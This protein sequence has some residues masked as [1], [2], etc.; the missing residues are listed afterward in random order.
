MASIS[1]LGSN[2][3]QL[4]N[5]TSL[6]DQMNLMQRQ[7]STGKKYSSY[8]ELGTNNIAVQRARDLIGN[9][10]SLNRN[11]DTAGRR[12]EL[13]TSALDTIVEQTRKVADSIA[14]E[15]QRG[16]ADLDTI[17]QIAQTT[18]QLVSDL[19]NEQDG[20]RYLFNGSDTRTQPFTD[21]GSLDTF[22]TTQIDD[23][24]NENITSEELIDQYREKTNLSDSLAGFSASISSGTA[25]DISVRIENGASIN[26]GVKANEQPLRDILV[27]LKMIQNFTGALDEVDLNADAAP[28]TVTAPGV[29]QQEQQD[30]FYAVFND[31]ANM[32]NSAAN[33]VID[34]I[35]NLSQVQV[36]I[37]ESQE[38]HNRLI[39]VQQSIISDIEDADIN[40]IALRF[41]SVTTQL[42][43]SFSLTSTL[44]Q[45]SLLNFL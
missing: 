34:R 10:E 20:D 43:A 23:W 9:L 12:I 35:S 25:K 28:G 44:R 42:N 2:L 37:N 22:L 6:Q 16:E 19:I 5:L 29:G 8:S 4:R 11:I 38:D 3:D 18:F 31:L 15:N 36:Q 1:T 39:N 40:E 27:G 24:V 21:S 17:N 41:N 33:G 13:M 32:L 7:I 45:V 14:G 30:N 26:Y